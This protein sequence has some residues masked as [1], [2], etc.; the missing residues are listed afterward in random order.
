MRLDMSQFRQL[1]WGNAVLSTKKTCQLDTPNSCPSYIPGRN[2]SHKGGGVL[3][4]YNP[5]TRPQCNPN[6][7]IEIAAIDSAGAYENWRVPNPP[8]ANP[9][10][11][12]RA[13]PTSDYWGRTGV[14]RCAEERTGICRDFQ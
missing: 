6:P 7:E 2:R 13:F 14:A 5:D 12:E 8:G 1:T 10:V 11:A 3:S 9:L 4:H